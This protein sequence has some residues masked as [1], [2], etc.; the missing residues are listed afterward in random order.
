MHIYDLHQL[1]E[2]HGN[3]FLVLDF[4]RLFI[5]STL[6]EEAWLL[7][8]KDDPALMGR[9]LER[10]A[11]FGIADVGPD[12]D[13][14]TYSGG[15]RAILACLLMLAAIATQG[16]GGIKLLLHNLT[17]S[18]SDANRKKL[19]DHLARS[20]ESHGTRAFESRDGQVVEVGI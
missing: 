17:D 13:L 20:R 4:N 3:E 10:A 9:L 7:L 16:M 12:R 5:S 11:G 18:L 14:T 6:R 8:Q 15:E 2:K 19:W 1:L